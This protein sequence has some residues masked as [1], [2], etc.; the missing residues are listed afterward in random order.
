M[1]AMD[2][3]GSHGPCWQPWTVLA[4][5][6]RVGSHGPRRPLAIAARHGPFCSLMLCCGPAPCCG[7]VPCCGPVPLLR[8]WVV[9]WPWTV[10]F[11]CA[12]AVAAASE[13]QHWPRP[14]WR[15]LGITD[16]H[17]LI[18]FWWQ[19][20]EGQ[21]VRSRVITFRSPFGGC[22]D[23]IEI[24]NCTAKVA[25]QQPEVNGGISPG[26]A[27]LSPTVFV[28]CELGSW[29]PW[30]ECSRTC[31]GGQRA[32]QVKHLSYPAPI[33]RF[34]NCIYFSCSARSRISRR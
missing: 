13:M 28:G 20:G 14:S 11:P 33:I 4:A 16:F 5:L 27:T 24:T 30:T 12:V 18:I 22:E 17:D 26:S 29:Q 1:A 21:Q 23:T 8:P 19:V 31:A 2:R 34:C 7:H 6:D 3:V 15:H 25:P 10:L 32:R 9:L